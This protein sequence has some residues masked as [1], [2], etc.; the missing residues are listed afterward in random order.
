M[1][2]APWIK[3][4]L[5]IGSVI[6]PRLW[7]YDD[8][9]EFRHDPFLKVM[10]LN[11][12]DAIADRKHRRFQKYNAPPQVSKSTFLEILTTLWALTFWP[13]SRVILV[14]YSDDIAIK[15]G[16]LVRDII[17]EWGPEFGLAIDP[18][19]DSKQEWRLV[20]SM[21]GMLSVGIGSRI[22]GQ[23]GDLIIIG[24]V[25]K[26]MEEA[27]SPGVLDKHWDEYEGSVR[28]RLQPGGT[29]LLGATRFS[30]QDISGRLDTKA[31][32]PGYKGDLWESFVFKAIAEPAIDE[33]VEDDDEWRDLLGRRRG[34]PLTTRFSD[35]ELPES[36]PSTWDRHHFQAMR[37][38]TSAFTYSCL[39]QQE[40]T[41][42]T[43][44]MFPQDRWGWYDPK[45]RPRMVAM[46]RVWDLAASEGSGDWTVG[47]LVGKD[48]DEN[49]YVLDIQRFQKGP[50]SALDEAILTAALD[51][52]AVPIMVEGSRNGDG[53]TVVAF[54]AK[55]LRKYSV[56][57]ANADG[58]K[59]TRAR[60]YSVLQQKGRVFLPRFADGS[61]P[62]WVKAFVE[63]HRKMMGDGRKGRHD[64]QIDVCAHAVNAMIDSSLVEMLMPHVGLKASNH[65]FV[66]IDP[67]A[68]EPMERELA[69]SFVQ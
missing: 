65:R 61:K 35:P 52:V 3:S 45:E 60:P 66:L 28:T 43:G 63:E 41:S 31:A 34:E 8:T 42:P 30:D 27:R 17:Q 25:I 38:T 22:T 58:S 5:S 56:E 67:D 18:K 59:E 13:N 32:E 33:D 29:M 2:V 39:Y 47:G 9:M 21:G 10:E 7:G 53:K 16:S 15:S 69:K 12:M 1:A 46:R 62:D 20:G 4:P 57:Q 64:D 11:V 26:N 49:F 24:D 68:D 19:Y 23:S 54:Y 44:G 36:D 6:L 37:N 48:A 14:A 55:A 50:D 40:P 51:G